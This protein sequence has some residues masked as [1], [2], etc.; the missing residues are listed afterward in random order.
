MEKSTNNK[1][2]IPLKAIDLNKYKTID[3]LVSAMGY[4]SFGARTLS[5]ATDI[6][7]KMTK[8]KDC[9]RV[10]TLSGAM[11]IAQMSLVVCDMIENNMVNAIVTTGALIS[12][13]F[14]E[15]IGLKHFKVPKNSTDRNLYLKQFN[16]VYDTLEA[17]ENFD[18]MTETFYNIL[19][20]HENEDFV[21]SH[22]L[23]TWLGENFSKTTKKRGILKSAYNKNVPIF[24][25]AFTDSEIG[26]SFARYNHKKTTNGKKQIVFNPFDDLEKY[27]QLIIDA[28]K[29][30]IFTVGGGVPRNW[31]Q[32]VCPYLE[33]F[34]INPKLKDKEIKKIRDKKRKIQD[35]DPYDKK[36]TY[37]IRI[38]PEPVYWGGLSGCTYSE[39]ISWGKFKSEDEAGMYAEVIADA[40][41][42]WPII[43]KAVLERLSKS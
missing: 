33:Y 16:R 21:C 31:A 20:S 18:K 28:K 34:R 6:A 43:I 27:K 9:F 15:S 23:C 37:G 30:G 11:T 36:F 25:P 4:S 41:I 12:H 17:E 29:I 8:D 14:I 10:L 1:K 38:C 2:L 35:N 19:D 22:K 39:G 7:Y 32:Q 24:I 13:G 5:E 3:N 26:M 40:T 42:A